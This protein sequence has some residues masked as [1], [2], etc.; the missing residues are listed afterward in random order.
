[1]PTESHTEEHVDYGNL[2]SRAWQITW[3]HKILWI[4]GILAGRAGGGFNYSFSNGSGGRNPNASPLPP[5]LQ[6]QLSRPE[7]IT[8]LAVV[9][10]VALVVGIILFLVGIVARGG[11]IGGIKRAADGNNLTF[12]ETWSIGTHNFAR[13]LGLALILAVPLIAI[14]VV[15]AA[16]AIAT[17]GIGLICVLPLLCL[18]IPASVVA[19]IVT[20]L[21]QYT[22]V[23]EDL[24]VMDALH[25]AWALL[26]ANLGTFIV[27]GLIVI[28]IEFVVGIVLFLPVLVVVIPTFIA[29]FL[30]GGNQPNLGALALGGVAF[31]C[32]LPILI[33]LSGILNTWSTAFWT[34]LYGQVAGSSPAPVLAPVPAPAMP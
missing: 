21:A 3:K 19:A 15:F 12:R 25:R 16:I 26:K 27:G 1:M 29:V 34:L 8:I 13:L 33:V 4:F 32:Y 2:L 28:F 10:C 11:L 9:V 18:I 20:G 30:S 17:A 14:A 7:V 5:D 24:R 31:V 23:L 22:V 6:T